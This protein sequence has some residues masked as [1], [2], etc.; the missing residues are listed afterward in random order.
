[1]PIHSL[2]RQ[3]TQNSSWHATK[4]Q[5]T[6]F[7]QLLLL[8]KLLSSLILKQ[9][10][11]KEKLISSSAPDIDLVEETKLLVLT[12]DAKLFW[13]LHI[14]ALCNKLCN[15][16]DKTSQLFSI[17]CKIASHTMMDS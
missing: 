6:Q 1:M 8:Q 12:I 13:D 16:K 2:L 5:S 17:S 14:D 4:V 9:L 10:W 11:K 3:S 15:M 7:D